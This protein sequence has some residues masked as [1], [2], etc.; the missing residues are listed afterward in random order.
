MYVFSGKH[1]RV[2]FERRTCFLDTMN[3]LQ[4]IQSKIYEIWGQKVIIL[5]QL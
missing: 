3:E 2:F 1:V 4:L 5:I